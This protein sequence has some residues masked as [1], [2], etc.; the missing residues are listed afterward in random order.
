MTMPCCVCSQLEGDSTNDLLSLKLDPEGVYVRR[1]LFDSPELATIP[2]I[3]GLGDAH[4]LVCPKQHA[5]RFA[6]ARV[7]VDTLEDYVA[8]VVARL[9]QVTD[10][11]A[12][13]LFEHGNPADGT[14]T[15]CSVEHA[16]L[17]V[18]ASGADVWGALSRLADWRDA[19]GGFASIRDT[20]GDSEYLYYRGP[21]GDAH[22]ALPSG[23]SPFES[24]LI[25]RVFAQAHGRPGDWNWRE[26]PNLAS[27]EALFGALSKTQPAPAV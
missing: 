12:V 19:P 4:L 27:L 11:P 22:I 23:G 8:N 10:T 26:T 1:V 18:V 24:Q 2:S 6:S 14:F 5:P 3:G 13:H 17:H 7:S 15:V 20:V 9:R 25:R 21:Q 16:H